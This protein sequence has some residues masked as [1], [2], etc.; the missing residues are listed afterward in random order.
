MTSPP[1]A[2]RTQAGARATVLVAAAFLVGVAG[3][4]LW[5]YDKGRPQESG[6]AEA[7]TVGELSEA[8]R[9][10]LANLESPVSLRYYAIL[11]PASAA[12]STQRFAERVDALLAKYED[13][14]HGKLTLE[15]FTAQSDNGP[16]AATA[17]GIRAFNLDKGDACFLGIAVAANDQKETLP[18]LSPEWEAALESDLSRAIARVSKARPTPTAAFTPAPERTSF[19]EVRRAL[20]DVTAVTLEEGAKILRDSALKEAQAAAEAMQS[21][22]QAAQQRLAQARETGSEAEQ[23]AA[24]KDFQQVQAE[25]A[26]KLRAISTKLQEQ[27]AA[28]KQMKTE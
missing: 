27:I 22:I 5:F 16:Q 19:D 2:Y 13:A 12:D 25:Q 1:R 14:A 17:E 18:Q 23:Q 6:S 8:T 26:E 28:L 11:D 24:L 21:Q 4:A 3:A 15:R 7:E 20:P 10:I 9:S